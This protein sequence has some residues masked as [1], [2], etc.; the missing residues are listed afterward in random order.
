MIK[1]ME[2]VSYALGLNIGG[3][4][5]GS[6][7]QDLNIEQFAQGVKD[8]LAG[9]PTMSAQETQQTLNEYFSDLQKKMAEKNKAEETLFFTVNS[10]NEGVKTL[11]SGLQYKV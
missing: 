10:K 5:A 7:I 2:K 3:N 6:G 1:K 11:P 8:A 9:K 4:I